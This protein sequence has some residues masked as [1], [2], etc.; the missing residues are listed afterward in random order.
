[1]RHLVRYVRLRFTGFLK[2]NDCVQQGVLELMGRSGKLQIRK[3][4]IMC[5]STSTAR[6]RTLP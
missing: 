6:E 3:I 2:Y 1:M 5:N 4:K